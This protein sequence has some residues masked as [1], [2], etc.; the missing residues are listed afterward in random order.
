MDKREDDLAKLIR[1][2]LKS[3]KYKFVLEDLVMGIGS[4]ELAKRRNLKEAIKA[5]K[6]KLH[7]VGAA[8]QGKANYAL[9]LDKLDE[10]S[11]GKDK[12]NLYRACTVIMENHSSTRERLGILDEFYKTTLASI[13]PI[14]TVLDIACGL[15]PLAIPWMSLEGNTEYYAYDVYHDM[16]DFLNRFLRIVGF[17]GKAVACDVIE[18]P[19]T[20]RADVALILKA[21]PCLEQIDKSAPLRLLDAINAAHLL[22]SFP[23]HSLGGRSKGM[24]VNYEA[25]FYDL[26]AERD[27]SVKRFEFAT[28]LAFLVVK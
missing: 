28:E 6:N 23:R 22:V 26:I 17:E 18:S 8:Y 20:R 15:N 14:R 16:I 19:P 27:W 2:V 11:R 10:A 25:R 9:W 21:L 4:R 3:S 5:T 1:S 24:E 13:T 7:Q 12:H